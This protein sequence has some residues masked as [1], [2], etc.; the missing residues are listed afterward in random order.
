MIVQL[1]SPYFYFLKDNKQGWANDLNSDMHIILFLF[2]SPIPFK[3][4]CFSFSK[5]HA[6]FVKELLLTPSS[7]THSLGFLGHLSYP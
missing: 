6:V 5:H 2:V 4:L 7:K 1:Y 3:S